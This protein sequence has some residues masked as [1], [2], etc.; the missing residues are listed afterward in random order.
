MKTDFLIS[1][2]L[3]TVSEF[4]SNLQFYNCGAIAIF[5]GVVRQSN[6]RKE[7]QY[8]EFEAYE[9]MVCE[10][11]HQISAQLQE[12]FD[13]RVVALHHRIGK[14]EPGETAVLAGIS[15]PH[16]ADA[17]NALIELMNQLK[18]TVPIWKKE[19]Y[20]DGYYWVSSTP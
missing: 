5:N 17:F 15:A 7:V 3:I 9:P 1:T 18:K 12:Q 19:V 2:Q 16:R 13:L 20:S 11:L 4:D 8:L 6:Q 10:Q 14:V